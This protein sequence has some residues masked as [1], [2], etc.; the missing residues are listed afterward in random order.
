MLEILQ[1]QN[2]KNQCEN[3]EKKINDLTENIN[4]ARSSICDLE[5]KLKHRESMMNAKAMLNTNKTEPES[6]A[7][8]P[9]P[10]KKPINPNPVNP[11]RAALM[12][13]ITK[14]KKNIS[15]NT[16]DNDNNEKSKPKRPGTRP[17]PALLASI[18]GVK[19]ESPLSSAKQ[20]APPAF[21][22]SIRKAG[23]DVNNKE[24]ITKSPRL[25]RVN[26]FKKTENGNT[27]NKEAT[28]IVMNKKK[29]IP[30]KKMKTL[31]WKRK[32]IP[33]SNADDTKENEVV[34][35]N[36]NEIDFNMD[37][38]EDLFCIPQR[39]KPQSKTKIDKT[40]TER[41]KLKNKKLAVYPIK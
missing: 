27:K 10:V 4:N 2:I 36:V 9:D 22:A 37:E 38:F 32:I 31:H 30:N 25:N 33:I 13:A 11:A 7:T 19:S 39:N 14:K 41:K 34:W 29:I 18:R 20:R 24:K 16:N 12:A 8:T 23:G 17:N 28:E 6:D 40:K 3:L 35:N 26:R 5:N 15:E 1:K 21:L